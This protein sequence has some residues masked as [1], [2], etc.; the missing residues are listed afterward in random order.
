MA[1]PLKRSLPRAGISHWRI[2]GKKKDFTHLLDSSW[3]PAP[4]GNARWAS[5]NLRISC[6]YH[7]HSDFETATAIPCLENIFS[8][9][10]LLWSVSS[11]TEAHASACSH[12]GYLDCACLWL[13]AMRNM[14]YN[15]WVERSRG[16]STSHLVPFLELPH[17]HWSHVFLA[18]APTLTALPQGLQ[19][20]PSLHHNFLP[21]LLQLSGER[22]APV[23]L[24]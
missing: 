21:L 7:N 13:W 16:Q 18:W 19:L 6:R 3:V 20:V 11:Y 5:P 15:Y 4:L 12:P 23:L 9:F 2:P 22:S 1:T 17:W 8:I 14:T 24:V 10:I